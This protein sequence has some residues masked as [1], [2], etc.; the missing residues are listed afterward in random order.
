M[1]FCTNGGS[2]TSVSQAASGDAFDQV[3]FA[4]PVMCDTLRVA[5][6]DAKDLLVRWVDILSAGS[7]YRAELVLDDPRAHRH[8]HLEG[9][10]VEELGTGGAIVHALHWT[11]RSAGDDATAMLGFRTGLVDELISFPRIMHVPGGARA[12]FIWTE[13][14]DVTS[15]ASHRAVCFGRSDISRP[16]EAVGGFVKYGIPL[17]KT[18]FFSNPNRLP[19]RVPGQVQASMANEDLLQLCR[20]LLGLGWDIGIH[21]PQPDNSTRKVNEQAIAFFEHEFDARTWIDHGCA[22]IRNGVSAWGADS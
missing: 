15:V 4:Q 13:H 6:H 5:G 3:L 16:E 11:R 18:L 14:A 8:Y 12:A 9:D 21:S 7:D 17:T 22:S 20:T 2:H 19:L 1:A 10:A